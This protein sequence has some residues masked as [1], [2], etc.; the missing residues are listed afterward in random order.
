MGSK[1]EGGLGRYPKGVMR[2]EISEMPASPSCPEAYIVNIILLI[3]RETELNQDNSVG[4]RLHGAGWHGKWRSQINEPHRAIVSGKVNTRWV[5]IALI[6]HRIC[7]SRKFCR[8]L[9]N[10]GDF[11]PESHHLIIPRKP[12]FCPYFQTNVLSAIPTRR[13][14]STHIHATGECLFTNY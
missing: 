4:I 12:I 1:G 13:Y 3:N 5:C 11:L 9:V 14:L 2:E 8:K 7:D 10:K 6:K